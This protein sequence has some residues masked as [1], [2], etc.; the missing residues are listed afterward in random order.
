MPRK[1]RVM[2]TSTYSYGGLDSVEAYREGACSFVEAAGTEGADLV[3]LPEDF[4][5][6]G[7]PRA[8]RP[9]AETIPGPTINAI[10][11][12]ARKHAVWVVV[13]FCVRDEANSG[14]ITNCAVVVDRTGEV[15]G[16]YAK[17][18]PTV[19]ECLNG[20]IVPGSEPLVID[21]DFGRVGLAICYDIGWP[22]YWAKLRYAGA[23]IVV[24]PSAYDGGFPLQ[25]YAW[26][27]GYY[28]VSSVRTMHARV[29]DITGQ[30]LASTSRWHRLATVTI[31][32][33]KELFHTDEHE[34]KILQI[35]REMGSQVTIQAF[36][37]EHMFTLESH[38]EGWPVSRIKE[39]YGLENF[40]DYHAR[41]SSVQELQRQTASQPSSVVL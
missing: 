26:S 31:D 35:Q 3:C 41:A 36:S 39:H 1:V 20:C 21:T 5:S 32:L 17:V 4:L 22:E 23:E 25:S 38:D 24:W 33:E 15:V 7:V 8:Q 19:G 12:L 6:E 16:Q 11:A 30:I 2:T 13:P 27:H 28:V 29:I 9:F 10:A 40:R 18:H 14:Q 34:A 37:E